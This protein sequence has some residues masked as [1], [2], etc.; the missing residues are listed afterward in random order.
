[1]KILPM[2]VVAGLIAFVA[3]TIATAQQLELLKP[4]ELSAATEGT[5]PPFSMTDASG[6]LEG[7]EIAVMGEIAKRLGLQYKPVILKWES[8]LIGLQADQYDVTSTAMDITEERQ[9]SVTFVDGWLE[10]GGR[11]IVKKDSPINTPA[12]IKGKTVGVL[13]ASTWA[14]LAEGLGAKEVKQYKAESD[15]LQDLVSGNIDGVVTDAIAGAFA[16]QASKMPLKMVDQPLSSIQKGFAV[17]KGKPNLV[18][19]MNKALADMVADGT[20]EKLTKPIVG[21]SPAPKAP[22]RSQ[23]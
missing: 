15:A 4:G 8:M 3:P 16:I 1:M 17:K 10:S 2:A 7:L 11:L 22:I 12:D 23:L 14:K 9:K 19:A 13:V 5:F 21:F 20:Y 18:K 6:K